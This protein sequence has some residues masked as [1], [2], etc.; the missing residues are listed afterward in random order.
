MKI[1]SYV[2]MTRRNADGQFPVYVIVS[3]GKGRFFVNTGLTTC[4]RLDG[5]RFP[6]QDKAWR[7]KTVALGSMIGNVER[8]CLEQSLLGVDNKSLKDVIVREVFGR[9]QRVARRRLVDAVRAFCMTKRKATATLYGI[10]ERK[11]ESFDAKAAL[12]DV[13][14][15]WLERFR[16]WCLSNGMKVNGAGKELRNLR[17]V[18]NWARKEG[19]TSNYP[20]DGY[21]I[22]EEETLPNNLSVDELRRL[23]DYPC[24]PWQRKYV[25]FFMLSFY[26]AGMNPVDLLTLRKDAVKGGHVS[27]V[28]QKTNKEGAKK[29]RTIVLPLVDEARSII[30]RYP[31]GDCYLLGFMDG[32]KD[33]HSFMKKCNEA[34]KK[35]GT[36]ELVPDKTGR[37]RKVKYHA[38]FPDL[39]LYSARYTFG[40]I[41]ANDLDISEQTI[42]RCLGHSWTK[43]VT[44]RYIAHDQ[45]KVDDAVR[46]VA[47]YV[48]SSSNVGG[49][50]IVSPSDMAMPRM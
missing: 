6:K 40:S 28:R 1:Y 39:T 8:V 15:R 50:G 38:L 5:G 42:G 44:A 19:L 32:R 31:G 21:A 27:F 43:H 12:D 33:Y 13:D 45:R 26:L 46:R 37:L 34:L 17:A 49:G 22:V 35:I 24:E 20:F 4:G 3:N 10:T 30:G 36:K 11:V 41:A 14:A 29:I 7:Q 48:S 9:E 18:F 25:D 23:R 16:Q 47:D 2:D